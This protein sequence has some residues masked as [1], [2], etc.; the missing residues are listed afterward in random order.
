MADNYLGNKMEEHLAKQ[1]HSKA[2]K[3]GRSFNQ[4]VAENRSYRGFDRSF[5][6][7]EH[8]LR[9]MLEICNKLPSARNQQV[10]RYRMVWGE[11]ADKLN[12]Y[13]RLGG[14]LPELHLPYPGT[15]P[16]AYIVICSTV[17]ESRYVSVDLGIAAQSILLK[18][19]DMGLHG[20]CI[21]AFNKEAVKEDLQ[22][23]L[24]PLL[25]LGIGKGAEKIVLKEVNEGDSLSYYRQ[26]G[27]HIVPKISVENLLIH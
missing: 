15:E 21:G 3:S 14:A 19:V 22:L 12:R 5:E 23:P 1:Q 17:E 16:G 13:I 9:R 26:D 10:L 7:K 18:A 6:V 20:I 2:A 11:E 27:L 25:L 4:L 24:E 8:H